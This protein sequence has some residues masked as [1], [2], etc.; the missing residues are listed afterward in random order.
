MDTHIS[1]DLEQALARR[2]QREEAG[3]LTVRWQSA[4]FPIRRSLRS[5]APGSKRSE[6]WDDFAAPSRSG[7][8]LKPQEAQRVSKAG[9]QL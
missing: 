1:H 8:S 7:P 6:S 3:H 9:S 4:G 5:R 2:L